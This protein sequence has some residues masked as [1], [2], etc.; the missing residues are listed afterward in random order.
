MSKSKE[1]LRQVGVYTGSTLLTQLITLAA[2][3]FS[4]RI[5]GPFQAGVW[6]TLQV[7]VDYSKYSTLGVM[8][9]VVRDIPFHEGRGDSRRAE[10]IKNTAF[11]FIF[12][13][14]LL[15]AFALAFFAYWVRHTYRKE[16]VFGLFLVAAIIILQRVNNLLICLLRAFKKFNVESSQMVFS[17]IVNA[18][19]IALLTYRFKIYGFIFAMGLSFLFNIVYLLVKFPFRFRYGLDFQKIKPLVAFGLPLMSLGLLM[20]VVKSLDRIMLVKTLGFEPLGLYSIALMA[21]SYISNFS[22]SFGT[23]L[24]SY[25]QEKFAM[26]GNPRGMA[27]YVKKSSKGYALTMPILIGATA[28][29]APFLVHLFLPKFAGAVAALRILILSSFFVALLQP[30][31]DFLITIRKH[32]LLFPFLIGSILLAWGFYFAVGTMRWGIEAYA[33]VVCLVFFAMFTVLYALAA[34]FLF[35]RKEAVLFYLK[36]TACFFYLV[37]FDGA[38]TGFF[39]VNDGSLRCLVIQGL[40]YFLFSVPLC[41]ILNRHFDVFRVLG[42]RLFGKKAVS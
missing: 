13:T 2:A 37:V 23:V 35:D 40:C 21:C 26:I 25:S 28:F 38:L 4:R 17:S 9:A 36:L 11:S 12:T 20:T 27:D 32:L 6:T 42:D 22:I 18:V 39:S 8:E 5:L 31:Y 14:S 33:A 34:R 10:E 1:I 7:V 29:S 3:V 30:Y 41:L 16:V 15:I 19:L 24:F